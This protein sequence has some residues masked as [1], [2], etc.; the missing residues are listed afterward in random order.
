MYDFGISW[1]R[2]SDTRILSPL[3]RYKLFVI[4]LSK[5]RVF[6]FRKKF[7][8]YRHD[9]QCNFQLINYRRSVLHNLRFPTS[10]LPF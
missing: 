1:N 5:N 4:W 8:N 6:N 3:F 7:I 9:K 10:T 2:T